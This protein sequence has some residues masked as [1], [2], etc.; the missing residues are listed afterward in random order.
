MKFWK[1]NTKVPL[2]LYL[3]FEEGLLQTKVVLFAKKPRHTAIVIVE[4]ANWGTA[5]GHLSKIKPSF[6]KGLFQT[7]CVT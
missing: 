5:H 3:L 4:G 7:F 1:K 6:L 2:T